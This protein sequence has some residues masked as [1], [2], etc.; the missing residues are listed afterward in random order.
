[1]AT[2]KN[3]DMKK[4]TLSKKI[5]IPRSVLSESQKETLSED[6]EKAV[7]KIHTLKEKEA[8]TRITVDVPATRYKA[9]RLMLLER[10]IKFIN[11]YIV[12]LIEKDMETE[13]K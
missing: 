11:T 5:T 3:L 6:A 12:G 7:N 10:N 8:T 9:I 1:M 13:K 4:L 2:K